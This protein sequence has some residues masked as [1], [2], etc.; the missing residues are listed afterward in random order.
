M[1]LRKVLAQRHQVPCR[2]LANIQGHTVVPCLPR[3]KMLAAV[4]SLNSVEVLGRS[5]WAWSIWVAV[6]H[7]RK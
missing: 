3:T 7:K 6:T 4:R 2:G 5:S 1:W